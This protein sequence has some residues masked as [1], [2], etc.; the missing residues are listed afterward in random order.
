MPVGLQRRHQ[1]LVKTQPVER[2]LT[3]AHLGRKPAL[4]MHHRA[5]A[6]GLAGAQMTDCLAGAFDPLEQH[7]Q[8][9]AA[10]LAAKQT[11]GNDAGVVDHQQVTG[12]QQV[13][14][15]GELAIA[16]TA[17]GSVQTKE[18][19]RRTRGERVLGDEFRRELVTEIR[20]PHGGRILAVSSPAGSAAGALSQAS[21]GGPITILRSNRAGSALRTSSPV[22]LVAGTSISRSTRRF[23]RITPSLSDSPAS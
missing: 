5:L 11:G 19:A 3:P 17:V 1:I 23:S 7:L 6:S 15:V 8:L 10:G 2:L 4:K 20:A 12:P 16:Q 13:R 14:Q 21:S 22:S 9:T 18:T